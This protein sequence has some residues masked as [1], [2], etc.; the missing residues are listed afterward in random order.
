MC[1]DPEVCFC[2]P[3]PSS[4]PP[5]VVSAVWSTGP[6]TCSHHP[7]ARRPW[8]SLPCQANPEP[9]APS[10]VSG[11]T[12]VSILPWSSCVHLTM[13]WRLQGLSESPG[14]GPKQDWRQD[15]KEKMSV[16][17]A[18]RQMVSSKGGA[19][20]ELRSSDR[21][22]PIGEKT[23]VLGGKGEPHPGLHWGPS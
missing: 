8:E 7:P 19:R 5:P 1:R 6:S 10:W 17:A 2:L 9:L 21:D 3:Q 14:L 15:W 4:F 11:F 16:T 22:Q 12:S 23:L 13:D 18:G 20:A